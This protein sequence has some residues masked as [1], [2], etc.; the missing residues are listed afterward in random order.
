MAFTQNIGRIKNAGANTIVLVPYWFQD[1]T[2]SS[3]VFPDTARTI[4]DSEFIAACSGVIESG[5][6]LVVKPHIDVT[7]G[8]PR[9]EIEPVDRNAW[10]GSYLEFVLHYATIAENAGAAVF[11]VGTE[12]MALSKDTELWEEIIDS[13]QTRF[14]GEL[15]YSACPQEAL[16]VGFWDRLDYIGVNAWFPVSKREQPALEDMLFAWSTWKTMLRD[17]SLRFGRAVLITEI[18][19]M[20]SSR[21]AKNPGDFAAA[22]ARDDQLQADCYRAALIAAGEMDFLHGMVWWQWELNTP[23]VAG[24][25]DYTPEG[26]P[27]EM[28]LQEYWR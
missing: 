6:N 15:T 20:N 19:Y 14:H 12:F 21:T 27:A 1:H 3:A 23:D 2:R 28:I 9:A 24:G 17:I 11:S 5:L 10:K 13:C 26:K 16:S 8:T 4:P 22:G 18:G 25:V 7:S